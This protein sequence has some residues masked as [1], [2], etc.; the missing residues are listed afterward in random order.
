MQNWQLYNSPLVRIMIRAISKRGSRLAFNIIRAYDKPRFH[1][2]FG[3]LAS[4]IVWVST[5]EPVVDIRVSHS[6]IPGTP[7]LRILLYKKN[8]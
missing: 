3:S 6:I 5:G 8:R 7:Y 4:N 1:G 2:H